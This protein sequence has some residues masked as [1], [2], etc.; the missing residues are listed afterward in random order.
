MNAIRKQVVSTAIR[1]PTWNN[2][3]IIGTDIVETI[4]TLKEQ[5]GRDIVQ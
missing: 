2:T 4:R 3:Q 1:Y 5:S